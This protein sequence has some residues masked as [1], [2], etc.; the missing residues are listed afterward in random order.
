MDFRH[1]T[2][3]ILGIGSIV[4]VLPF[5][6]PML[7]GDSELWLGFASIYLVTGVLIGVRRFAGGTGRISFRYTIV[8]AA[9][10]VLAP[11]SLRIQSIL[12]ARPERTVP[13]TIFVLWQFPVLVP[14][15][16]A[17]MTPLGVAENRVERS[18]AAFLVLF[19]FL[20]ATIG[21][22]VRDS[23]FGWGFAVLYSGVLFLGGI[24]ESVP[25]YL[26]GRSLR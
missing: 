4:A 19:P 26:Y 5:L 18:I 25:L 6:F 13:D 12:A 8:V 15:A 11:I 2:A 20:V 22:V 3:V 16:A 17:F 7:S 24:V 23:G 10:S 14:F 9:L 1:S 21:G